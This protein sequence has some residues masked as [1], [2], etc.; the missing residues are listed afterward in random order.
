ML[1]AEAD[2]LSAAN[3][4]PA[5]HGDQPHPGASSGVTSPECQRSESAGPDDGNAEWLR[6]AGSRRC[7]ST[8]T[9]IALSAGW[10]SRELGRAT[11]FRLKSCLLWTNGTITAPTRSGRRCRTNSGTQARRLSPKLDSGIGRP[12]SR[13]CRD[14]AIGPEQTAFQAESGRAAEFQDRQPALNA[15]Q[16]RVERHR[17]DPATLSHSAFPSS[18]SAL[19]LRWHSGDVT[20]EEA[21]GCG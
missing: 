7:R 16:V 8:R 11:Q 6:V 9:W 10:R 2:G 13:R 20:P 12:G 19:S 21:P 1:S 14:S 17:R 18:G 5:V 4:A 3:I 15:I